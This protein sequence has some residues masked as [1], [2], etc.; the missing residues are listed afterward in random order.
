MKRFRNSITSLIT[1][2]MLVSCVTINIY[3][4][5]AAAEKAADRIIEDI[6]GPEGQPP[7]KSGPE[8]TEQQSS[9]EKV[10][11]AILDWFITPAAAEPDLNINSAAVTAIQANMKTRHNNLKPYF[12]NGAV[13]LTNQGLVGMHNI[14]AVSLKDRNKLNGLIADENK[15]RQALYAEIARANGH[16]EWQ[17]EI[18]AT[19][20]RR[21]IDK[22]A[23][24]WWYQSG[25]SWKQK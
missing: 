3:F 25:S 9:A 11:L 24:G 20:A 8:Q 21:W 6:W 7:Q 2:L 5:A 19:F 1:G 18:Q 10:G 16:P 13:G 23:K 12:D 17:A 22:A 15:D 14:K 4:P